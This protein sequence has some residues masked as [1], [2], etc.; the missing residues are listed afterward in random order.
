[1]D[2]KRWQWPC[3]FHND[4]LFGA[5]AGRVLPERIGKGHFEESKD[6]SYH[7]SVVRVPVQQVISLL[8]PL[9]QNCQL[10]GT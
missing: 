5:A 7:A 9:V 3:C 10:F 8:D 1:M 4:T 6:Y 2:L